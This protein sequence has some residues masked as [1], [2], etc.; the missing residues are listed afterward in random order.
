MKTKILCALYLIFIFI[1]SLS[2]S[3]SGTVSEIIY[4]S[5]FIIPIS[6]GVYY[7]YKNSAD[8]K[9]FTDEFSSV[10]K[11]RKSSALLS[12]PLFFPAIALICLASCFTAFFM[13]L[14]GY[15]NSPSVN[16]PFV[17]A[18]ILHALLPAILE[19]LLFRLIPMQLFGK[20]QKKAIIISS[21]FFSFAHAN[22]FQLPY[23]FLAGIIF[24]FIYLI[25]GSVIPGIVLH[26][27]NNA[28]SLVSIYAGEWMITASVISV[29]T[30]VSLIGVVRNRTTYLNA[31]SNILKG[32]KLQIESSVFIF[33][34]ISLV[35]AIS[36]LLSYN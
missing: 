11:L 24:S 15:E 19:E 27:L 7:L 23:A 8:K 4:Y 30:L 26:F 10:F 35:S 17:Y 36:S 1:I 34:F 12:L 22:L 16:E 20:E 32:E 13:E 29:L 2:A 3:F 9:S 14:F 28:I 33:I 6:F 31:V 18:L 5:A 25:S 21:L